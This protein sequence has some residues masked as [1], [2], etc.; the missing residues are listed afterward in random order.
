MQESDSCDLTYG[1]IKY[2]KVFKPTA[3]FSDLSEYI[4]K[5][6]MKMVN[7]YSI[8]FEGVDEFKDDF[9]T[10]WIYLLKNGEGSPWPDS[11]VA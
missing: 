8:E 3:Q 11:S 7:T 6:L 10:I 9:F 5:C 1:T 4:K 2:T